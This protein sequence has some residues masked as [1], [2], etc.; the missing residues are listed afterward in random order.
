MLPRLTKLE[1]QVM[2]ILWAHGPLPVREVLER[3]PAARRP[4]YTT[5]PNDSVPPGSKKRRSGEPARWGTPTYSNHQ[6]AAYRRISD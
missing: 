1:L 6:S 4:A 5:I 3:L 2:E